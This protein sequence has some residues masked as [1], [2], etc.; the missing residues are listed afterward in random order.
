MSLR[1]LSAILSGG[2]ELRLLRD[3]AVAIQRG[4]RVWVD[5]LVSSWELALANRALR[6]TPPGQLPLLPIARR[7]DSRAILSLQQIAFIERVSY[8]VSAMGLRVP[9]RSDCLVQALAARRW[10][11]R[12]SISSD[13]CIGVRKNEEGFQAHAWL[14]VGERIVTG[15]DTSSYA[16]LPSVDRDRKTF[17]E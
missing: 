14:K 11:A 12:A 4:P 2:L 6:R 3:V 7:E 15:G 16:E 13:V 17:N 5:L 9:W 1:G 8:A 10:L